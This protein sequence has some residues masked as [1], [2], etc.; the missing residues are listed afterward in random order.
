MTTAQD[1]IAD[2]LPDVPGCPRDTVL[3]HIRR[4][5]IQ[6]CRD[7]RAW[8]EEVDRRT[9]DESVT[10]LDPGPPRYSRIIAIASV[11][12]T[13][14]SRDDTVPLG[15]EFIDNEL[16]LL[17]RAPSTGT[18]AVRAHLEPIEGRD[19]IPAA[20]QRYT[21][22]LA[23]HARYRLMRMPNQ[24]WTDMNSAATHRGLYDERRFEVQRLVAQG[25]TTTPLRTA[26]QPFPL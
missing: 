21:E 5:V 9:I 10:V 19:E 8:E 13:I 25:N 6:A 2:V 15:H 17:D 3:Q 20:L 11:L 1:L 7:T 4:A 12:L 24:T 16:K 26:P 18:V 22:M 14:P 23:D